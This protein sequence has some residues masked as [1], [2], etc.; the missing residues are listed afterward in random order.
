LAKDVFL[1]DYVAQYKLCPLHDKVTFADLNEF[2]ETWYKEAKIDML[3]QGNILESEVKEILKRG[4]TTFIEK[5][6]DKS[7]LIEK[8]CRELPVGVNYLKVRTLLQTT[9]IQKSKTFTKSNRFHMKCFQDF[10]F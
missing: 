1:N 10:L 4:L 6:I 7:S 2:A 9:E 3:I 5:P 8:R